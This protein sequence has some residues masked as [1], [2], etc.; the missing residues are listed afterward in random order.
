MLSFIPLLAWVITIPSTQA[1]TVE[2]ECGSA[3]RSSILSD[4]LY[5]SADVAG[6][7]LPAIRDT[8]CPFG[9]D[10]YCRLEGDTCTFEAT[11]ETGSSTYVSIT[12][13]VT[14]EISA[15]QSGSL[16]PCPTVLVHLSQP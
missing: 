16:R 15:G 5:N 2:A 3:A 10:A 11:M 7:I 8:I 9:E 14:D 1:Q 13:S 6:N 4:E 12:V